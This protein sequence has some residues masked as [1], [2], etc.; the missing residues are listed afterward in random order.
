MKMRC[1]F[2]HLRLFAS[3]FVISFVLTGCGSGSGSNGGGGTQPV[4]PTGL[5]ATA[6]DTQVSLSWAASSGATNY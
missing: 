5:K 2:T 6:G 3:L 1:R 4:T